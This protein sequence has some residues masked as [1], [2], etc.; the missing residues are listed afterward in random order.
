MT[1]FAVNLRAL[2]ATDMAFIERL[3]AGSRAFE[4][5][6]S[7]WPAEQI[8]AFLGQQCHIQHT[9]YQTHYPDGQF[10]IIEHEG[11]AIGRL[12]LFWGQASLNLIDI[13]LLPDY[14]GKGIGTALIQ[15]QLHKVDAQGLG[16][17]LFV[18][19][20]NPALRLYTR[21]GFYANGDSGVYQR[22]RRDPRTDSRKVS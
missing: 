13:T 18:E 15:A 11:Q 14:Q 7:G 10:L 8:A 3:Y 16:V 12:Y 5:S 9:Y 1:M 4:M 2:Q 6:H 22:L 21:L 20:Y 19:P 17:D